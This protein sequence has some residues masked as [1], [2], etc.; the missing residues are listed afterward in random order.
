MSLKHPGHLSRA[1]SPPLA[2]VYKLDAKP[3]LSLPELSLSHPPRSFPRHRSS[4]PPCPRNTS[5]PAATSRAPA[6]KP[7][8]TPCPV[9]RRTVRTAPRRSSV[10]RQEPLSTRTAAPPLAVVPRRRRAR[11]PFKPRRS[12][13]TKP[14]PSCAQARSSSS[15]HPRLI[16][17]R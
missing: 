1:L 11:T 16:T 10:R 3:S 2:L 9:H 14:S 5:A 6:V 12:R 17:T 7:L 13:R 4:C 15:V 8:P